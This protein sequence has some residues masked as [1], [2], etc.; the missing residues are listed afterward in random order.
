MTP[1]SAQIFTVRTFGLP[2][3]MS[4]A[5]SEMHSPVIGCGWRVTMPVL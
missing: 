4:T 1:Q 5:T 3:F 2:V